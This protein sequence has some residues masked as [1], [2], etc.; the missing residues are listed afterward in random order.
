MWERA[1]M[2]ETQT[3]REPLKLLYRCICFKYQK[4]HMKFDVFLSTLLYNHHQLLFQ[5]ITEQ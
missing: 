3:D 2:T 5:P 1:D 4:E